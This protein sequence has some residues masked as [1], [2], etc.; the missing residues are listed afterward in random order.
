MKPPPGLAP[1]PRIIEAE[2]K[3]VT[4]ETKSQAEP[5]QTTK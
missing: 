4:D 1:A 2:A 3:P 5:W